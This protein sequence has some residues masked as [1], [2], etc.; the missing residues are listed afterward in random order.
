MKALSRLFHDLIH[1]ISDAFAALFAGSPE[2]PLVQRG[3]GAWVLGWAFATLMIATAALASD[4]PWWVVIP[5]GLL[6]VAG[7]LYWYSDTLARRVR[8]NAHAA[9][10]EYF[11]CLETLDENTKRSLLRIATYHYVRSHKAMMRMFATIW[12]IPL[13]V[14]LGIAMSRSH[15]ERISSTG[16]VLIVL[17]IYALPFLGTLLLRMDADSR[18]FVAVVGALRLVERTGHRLYVRDVRRAV[19][20]SLDDIAADLRR[21][22]GKQTIWVRLRDRRTRNWLRERG[23]RVAD[24]V[25]TLKRSVLIPDDKTYEKVLTALRILLFSISDGSWA[26]LPVADLRPPVR[27]SLVWFGAAA[28]LLFVL[29]LIG[30]GVWVISTDSLDNEVKAAIIAGSAP[31]A[32][33]AISTLAREPGRP[34]TSDT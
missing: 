5:L 21:Y 13:P 30:G 16:A 23:D 6:A 33:W 1:V 7:V 28:K 14:F 25:Y 29:A 15:N 27:R 18:A 20:H 11:W 19:A 17:G 22:I 3:A 12:A 34:G 8:R 10:R 4:V 31:L 24:G 26:S 9:I 32:L 2:G